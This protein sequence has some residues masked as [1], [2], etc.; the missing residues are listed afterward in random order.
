MTK[1]T[2]KTTTSP[3]YAFSAD[4]PELKQQFDAFI[5]ELVETSLSPDVLSK[6]LSARHR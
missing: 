5:N 1:T 2:L 6:A 4:T 3:V